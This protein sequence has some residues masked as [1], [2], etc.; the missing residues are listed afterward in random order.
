MSAV[1]RVRES[2]KLLEQMARYPAAVLG[3]LGQVEHERLIEELDMLADRAAAVRTEADL[4]DV[5]Q[6]I[7]RLIEKTP[8]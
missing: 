2:Q 5:A 3:S 4:L 7:R 8:V 6:E 1:E